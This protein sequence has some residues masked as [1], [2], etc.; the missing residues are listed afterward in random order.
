VPAKP[1]K[2]T[3]P[4]DGAPVEP[5]AP[6]TR[7]PLRARRAPTRASSNGCSTSRPSRARRLSRASSTASGRCAVAARPEFA[8]ILDVLSQDEVSFIVVGGVAA[9][10]SGAPV[11]TL[12][13][14]VLLERSPDNLERLSPPWSSSMPLRPPRRPRHHRPPDLLT[15]SCDHEPSRCRCGAGSSGCSSS[16]R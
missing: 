13:T 10:L 9:V 2:P 5:R 6:S 12:D 7:Q 8:A 11:N 4:G 14:D 16:G 1:R 15:R 3:S